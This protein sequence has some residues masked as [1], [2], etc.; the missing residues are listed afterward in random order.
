M[1]Y[2]EKVIEQVHYSIGQVAEIV[3]VKTYKI[4]EWSNL[5]E[6]EGII[7][8]MRNNKGDR[9]FSPKDLNIF[10]IINNCI[11]KQGMSTDGAKK[12]I[13]ENTDEERRNLEIIKHLEKI[14]MKLNEIK[15][16]L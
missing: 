9:I 5:F 10:E 3:G 2:K 8:P 15:D 12:R 16:L 7:K 13:V 6:S 4:R 14:K 1:P 11:T